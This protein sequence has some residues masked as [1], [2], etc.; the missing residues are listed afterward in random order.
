MGDRKAIWKLANCWK[1]KHELHITGDANIINNDWQ[2]SNNT[3]RYC[4]VSTGLVLDLEC[5]LATSIV[6]CMI[7]YNEL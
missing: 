6:G 5:W 1:L 3:G 2:A 4:V 7:T